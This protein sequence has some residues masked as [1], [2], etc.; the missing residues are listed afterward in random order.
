M[1]LAG[2]IARVQ[3]QFGDSS[4][5]LITSDE[6]KRWANDAQREIA[7]KTEC[8]KRHYETSAVQGD[9]SYT[10][11]PGFLRD[12]RATFNGR[13]ITRV[14]LEELD[15]Y[16]GNRDADPPTG[17]PSRFYVW[18]D[19]V[20]LYPAPESPGSG[21]FDM[22]Y[23]KLPEDMTALD[24]EP[25]VPEQYHEDIVRFCLARAKEVDEEDQKA[26]SL[27]AEFEARM[28]Q[29]RDEEFNRRADSYPSVRTL[30]GDDG[31]YDPRMGW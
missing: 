9:G 6:I 27:M 20:Y 12:V 16:E 26:E 7:R 10:L 31:F 4:G 21:N 1:N 30:P 5:A 13:K 29:S 2:I 23:I 3:T 15:K 28:S 24:Q 11:P 19:F 18:G 22:F 25:E 14:T 8:V 17:E